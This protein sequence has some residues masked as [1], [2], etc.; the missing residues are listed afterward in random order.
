M[1]AGTSDSL[2]C[3]HGWGYVYEATG[4]VLVSEKRKANEARILDLFVFVCVVKIKGWLRWGKHISYPD[5]GARKG[6]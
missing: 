6:I 3:R 4:Y 1:G 2:S 5:L